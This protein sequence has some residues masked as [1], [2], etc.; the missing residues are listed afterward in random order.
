MRSEA[1]S[2]PIARVEGAPSLVAAARGLRD[3]RLTAVALAREALSRI[4]AVDPVIRAFVR[5]DPDAAL[6]DAARADAELA[7][8]LDRGPL[9]GIPTA[10]K[11][12]LDVAGWPTTC[13]SRSRPDEPAAEDA[14]VVARL[15]AG[16]AVFLG[17]LETYEF[18]LGGPT[19]EAR[20]PPARNPWDPGRIPGGSSSGSA[21]AVAAGMIRMAPGSCTAGSIRGPA[22][23]CGIVGLKP[24]R[25]RVSCRGAFPLAPTLDHVGPLARSVEDAAIALGVM[26]G[27]D[28]RD[29]A[30]VDRPVPDYRAGLGDGV[31]GLR[32]GVPRHF[33]GAS[34]LLVPE[35]RDAIEAAIGHLR[36]AGATVT[37]VTLPDYDL[38]LAVNR[39]IMTAEALAIHAPALRRDPRAFAPITARRFAAGVAIGAADYLDAR[40]LRRGLTAAVDGVM[41]SVDLLLTAI[42]LDVAPLA[43]K[44]AEPTAWPLQASPFNVTGHP[45]MSVPAGFGRGGM[46]LAVQIVGQPFDEITVLRAGR[47]LERAFGRA[48]AEEENEETSA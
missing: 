19:E 26:A 38:F 40:R 28:P 44:G 16:G 10:I 32:V 36:A 6:A 45:A 2:C 9:H 23:W 25:G 30:S 3:G 33:F 34:P 18:A 4:A 27:H 11:D 14:G 35:A 17:K 29:E 21:A 1:Y 12:I 46:P 48:E 13:N 22:A 31:A 39:V 43:A 37:D 15:R 7:R 24:T 42:S 8:G 20:F 47:T 41:Q 5:L